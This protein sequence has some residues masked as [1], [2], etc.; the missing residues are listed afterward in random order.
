MTGFEKTGLSLVNQYIVID[1]IKYKAS[2]TT[3]VEHPTMIPDNK[4]WIHAKKG[5]NC[6]KKQYIEL[7][8]SP[9]QEHFHDITDSQ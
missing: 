6:I 7:F 3:V 2:S 4:R 5:I 9:T 8:R 1:Q